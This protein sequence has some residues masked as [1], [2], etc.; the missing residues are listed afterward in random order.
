MGCL[1][2]SS[3]SWQNFI[4]LGMGLPLEQGRQRGVAP[5]PKRRYFAIIG[6]FSVKMVADRYE[7][8][9]HHNKHW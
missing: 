8:A 2:V 9:A 5:P 6:S 4:P 7:H 3:F 1:K